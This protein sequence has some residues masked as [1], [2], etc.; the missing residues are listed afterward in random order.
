[1]PGESRSEHNMVNAKPLLAI[2]A[3]F[4]GV[5][6]AG[7]I[8]L[9]GLITF[10][11]SPLQSTG[12]Y[13]LGIIITV[14]IISAAMSFLS[15]REMCENSGT[16]DRVVFKSKHKTTMPWSIGGIISTITTVLPVYIGITNDWSVLAILFA[17]TTSFFTDA[18]IITAIVAV[19]KLV[20]APPSK[21]ANLTVNGD[22][23]AIRKALGKDYTII[24]VNSSN[25]NKVFVVR[26]ADG[27]FGNWQFRHAIVSAD[28][29]INTLIKMATAI[30]VEYSYRRTVNGSVAMLAIIKTVRTWSIEDLYGEYTKLANKDGIDFMISLVKSKYD[31]K[32]D[33]NTI[34]QGVAEYISQHEVLPSDKQHLIE[35]FGEIQDLYEMDDEA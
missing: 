18:I 32:E 9:L 5:L 19:V 3:T 26:S 33:Y 1:M 4:I 29:N 27:L 22:W 15:Y 10:T 21:Y 17:A 23:K 35:L 7:I 11:R 34:M 2:I 31:S 25:H 28:I 24:D 20:I 6:V 13:D 14:G 16:A 8:S 12:D 30:G